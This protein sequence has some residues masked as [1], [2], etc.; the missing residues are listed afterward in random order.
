MVRWSVVPKP[1]VVRLAVGLR[2]I[3]AVVGGIVRQHVFGPAVTSFDAVRPT[4]RHDG[5]PPTA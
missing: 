1:P 5:I 3:R 4:V 2:E